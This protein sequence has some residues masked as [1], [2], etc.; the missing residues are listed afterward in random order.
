[1]EG[2]GIS[3]RFFLLYIQ[4][5]FSSQICNQHST[6]LNQYWGVPIF[7]PKWDKKGSGSRHSLSRK[8]SG[9]AQTKP[10]S[11]TQLKGRK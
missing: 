2:A 10:P 4:L 6:L 8:L 11:L 7:R 3:A 9:R 5:L 1:M